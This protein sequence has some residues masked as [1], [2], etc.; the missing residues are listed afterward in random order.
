LGQ[1]AGP[2]DRRIVGFRRTEH[3][4]AE[5]ADDD[6]IAVG[7]ARGSGLPR[8]RAVLRVINVA[9]SPGKVGW[10]ALRSLSR[11]S[12]VDESHSPME[13]D[14]GTA[15]SQVFCVPGDRRLIDA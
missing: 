12:A 7:D 11:P 8:R 4:D 10:D 15:T 5:A 6:P 3:R 2:T 13:P 9:K 1:D 14:S